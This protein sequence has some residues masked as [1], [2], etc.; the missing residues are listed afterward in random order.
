MLCGCAHEKVSLCVCAYH[1]VYLVSCLHK[2][3]PTSSIVLHRLQVHNTRTH[4][5]FLPCR[6]VE[7]RRRTEP[8]VA[9][10]SGKR[11][12]LFVAKKHEA[13]GIL[14]GLEYHGYGSK[15]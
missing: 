4:A 12:R 7:E 6:W 14:E 11:D 13:L 1:H 8:A 2:G 5:R 10:G 3:L 15:A 9:S